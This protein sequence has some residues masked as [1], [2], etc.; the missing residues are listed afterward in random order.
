MGTLLFVIGICSVFGAIGYF[1][2]KGKVRTV[3]DYV[4]SRNSVNFSLTTATFVATGMGAW[5]LFAPIETTINFGLVALI[6]YALGGASPLIAFWFLG[7]KMRQVFPQGN[8]LAEF[9]QRRFGG[10]SHI[11]ILVV[12]I[13]YMFI[14]LTAELTAIGQTVRLITPDIPMWVLA[15]I[16]GLTTTAYTS[17][18][19]LRASIFTDGIQ[20]II[21]IPALIIIFGVAISHFGGFAEI[22]KRL[23]MR[24]QDKLDF[25]NQL[26]IETGIALIVAVLAANLLHQGYWQRIFSAEN[27]TVLK[28]SL[29]VSSMII[30][31]MILVTGF[32]G[33][34]ALSVSYTISGYPGIPAIALF[35]VI[36][37]GL[38]DYISLL[39]IVLAIALVMSSIDTLLNGIVSLTVTSVTPNQSNATALLRRS[40]LLTV[41]IVI[42]AILIASQE[43][44]VLYM[45][46]I[47]DLVAAGF[48]VPV[49]MGLYSSYTRGWMVIT[50]GF[51]SILISL[52]F[53]PNPDW[54]SVII[55]ILDSAH[56]NL[57]HSFLASLLV[58]TGLIIVF[59]QC[60]RASGKNEPFDF[61]TLQR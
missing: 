46:F 31:P 12:M 49:F 7:S 48:I 11:V 35:Q 57:M 22:G 54:S 26:G 17:Y 15:A 24:A 9:I 51:I 44:S 36:A 34:I 37:S 6:G 50:S 33:L 5:I 53:F 38:P 61:Q 52:L 42:P 30:V 20:F 16:I 47:A 25:T 27:T 3:Q 45:F 32:F 19:G 1:Y 23:V 8:T 43:P 55:P 14:F 41:A 2:S 13:F 29:V 39:V 4:V 10:T 59:Q 60:S 58:S 21:M 56:G 40:R 18:G 28:K